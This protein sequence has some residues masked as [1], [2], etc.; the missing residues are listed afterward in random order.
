M[1]LFVLFDLPVTT[2][3]ERKRA[4]HFRKALLKDGYIMIQFSVYARPC[5]DWIRL[6]KHRKRLEFMIP[7]QGSIRTL[8]ITDRQFQNMQEM[9]NSSKFEE[10][11]EHQNCEELLFF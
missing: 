4:T 2:K 10:N 1:W 7:P 11:K 9:I 3:S 8:P 6:E 5:G